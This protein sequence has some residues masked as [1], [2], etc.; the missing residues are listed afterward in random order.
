MW[1]VFFVLM[2]TA[3]GEL[4]DDVQDRTTE[5]FNQV[6]Y[7]FIDDPVTSLDDTHLIQMAISLKNIISESKSDEL[8]FIITTHHALFYNVLCNE[9]KRDRNITKK[10]FL[11]MERNDNKFFLDKQGDSPFGYHLFIKDIIQKA[12][13]NNAV[14]KYHFML[15]RNLLEKTA[16]YLG[17]KNWGDLISVDGMSEEDRQG[18]T[19]IINLFSHSSISDEEYKGLAQREKNMLKILFDSFI[20][21]YRWK[22]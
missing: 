19:R 7:I 13:N 6:Q 15:F 16:N 8:H 3:I 10:E 21:E 18:Y 20:K 5:E 4:N 12:I 17:Y 22:E 11:V 2:E 14:E 1:S 9:F